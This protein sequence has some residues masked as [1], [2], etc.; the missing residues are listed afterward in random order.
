MRE[1]MNKEERISRAKI[2]M[3]A[4]FASLRELGIF[5]HAEKEDEFDLRVEE[6]DLVYHG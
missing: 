4:A 1:K 5:V 6:E 3:G 2:I